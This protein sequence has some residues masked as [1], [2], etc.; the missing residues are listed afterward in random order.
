MALFAM[1]CQESRTAGLCDGGKSKCLKR[2][3]MGAVTPHGCEARCQQAGGRC[4]SVSLE[5][6]AKGQEKADVIEC[7]DTVQEKI[8]DGKLL[9]VACKCK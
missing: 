9:S 2:F 8:Q 7:S 4:W 1:G 3:E 6:Q 5:W